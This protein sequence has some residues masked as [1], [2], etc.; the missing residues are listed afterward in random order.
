MITRS[1]HWSVCANDKMENKYTT[2]NEIPSLVQFIL[3]NS[4][5]K[6]HN[7]PVKYQYLRLCDSVRGGIL[8]KTA[9]VPMT[10]S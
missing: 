5:E 3:K 9:K 6:T 4:N 1:S 10:K 2:Y 7:M 8:R